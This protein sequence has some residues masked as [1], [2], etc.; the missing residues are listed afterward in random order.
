[1]QRQPSCRSSKNVPAPTKPKKGRPPLPKGDAKAVMMRVRMTLDERRTIEAVAKASKQ[2]VSQ[3]VR[4]T[5]TAAIQG[6]R[7]RKWN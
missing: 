7:V 5:L 6:V 3:W 2:T 1:M 4:S